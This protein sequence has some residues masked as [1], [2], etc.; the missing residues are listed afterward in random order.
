LLVCF[1]E[2][3]VFLTSIAS[4]LFTRRD[5]TGFVKRFSYISVAYAVGSYRESNFPIISTKLFT[6]VLL[7]QR[8]WKTKLSS[9]VRMTDGIIIL[10]DNDPTGGELGASRY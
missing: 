10:T 1:I 6:V 2:V 7:T 5:S 8:A 4:L 9:G 3:L